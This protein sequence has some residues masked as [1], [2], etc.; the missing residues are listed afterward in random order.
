MC[1]H[2]R[3]QP[4]DSPPDCFVCANNA[5]V[6]SHP[7]REEIEVSGTWRIAHAFGTSLPGW[8]VVV[9]MRHVAALDE[10][11]PAEAGQLG[12]VLRRAS[13]ALRVVTGCEKAYFVFFA[14]QEG[15]AHLHVHVIP[16]M[17][18]FSAE[19]RGPGVF[20]FLGRS[21]ESAWLGEDERDR[22][23]LELRG[24]LSSA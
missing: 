8:L 19:Q 4:A 14:E 18:W 13:K 23:A 3:V 6:G 20:C 24:A 10:L 17:S 22:V 7:P 12:E 21:A 15:F 16:R 5:L 11:E 9:P 2:D 1:E